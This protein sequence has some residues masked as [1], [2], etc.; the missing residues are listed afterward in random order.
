MI[1]YYFKGFSKLKDSKELL[2]LSVK[3]NFPED[4]PC[5]FR[6]DT[7]KTV[8]KNGN[9]ENYFVSVSHSKDLWCCVFH[10]EPVGIDFEMKTP[11]NYGRISEKFFTEKEKFRVKKEGLSCFL[12]LWMKKEAAGKL[13]EIPLFTA[14]RTIDI[15]KIRYRELKL[16]TG[17]KGFIATLNPEGS[18]EIHNLQKLCRGKYE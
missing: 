11:V 14:L 13:L 2:S 3:L 18:M 8:L 15:E 1:A 5:I 6:K 9:I 10:N 12:E 4:T 7:G 17:D 16:P